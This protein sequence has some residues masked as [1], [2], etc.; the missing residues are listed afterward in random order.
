MNKKEKD[1]TYRYWNRV[2]GWSKAETA[3][4]S[5]LINCLSHQFGT[6]LMPEDTVLDY[7]CGTGS[8][9]LQIARNVNK[10][11]GAD[12]SEEMLKRARQNQKDQ[13]I[14]N[15][16]F[17]NITTQE[18]LFPSE[19]FQVATVFNVLQYVDNRKELF[20]RFYGLLKPEGV[21]L[22]AVPCFKEM[23]RLSRLYVKFLRII[24]IMPEIYFFDSDEIKEEITGAGFRIVEH[25]Q[26]SPLPDR[27]I[28][29]VKTI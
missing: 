29:A 10:V 26:I 9:T 17:H 5:P 18:E 22:I 6:Y 3:A 27:L 14:K 21:L 2:A 20:N 15:T 23:N 19:Y 28:I 8:I 12:I 13:N 25:I 1:K 24:R 11:Y 4:N 7:G 16:T